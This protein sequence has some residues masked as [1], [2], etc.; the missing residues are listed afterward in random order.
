MSAFQSAFNST[1]QFGAQQRALRTQIHGEQENVWNNKKEYFLNSF[2]D[3]ET[4][5]FLS[6]QQITESPELSARAAEFMNDPHV[7]RVFFNGRKFLGMVPT[8]RGTYTMAVMGDD[9]KP[10]PVTATGATA[11]ENPND[12]VLEGTP[13][14]LEQLWGRMLD[15]TF[16]RVNSMDRLLTG[17]EN[18]KQQALGGIGD[19]EFQANRAEMAQIMAGPGATAH[20]AGDFTPQVTPLG[21]TSSQVQQPQR[22]VVDTV[23]DRL[24]DHEGAEGDTTGAAETGKIGVTAAARKAVGGKDKTDEQVARE[25]LEQLKQKMPESLK[26]APESVQRAILDSAYNLGESIFRYPKL[27]AAAEKGDWQGVAQELLDTASIAGKSSRGLASRR[28]QAYNEIALENGF[29]QIKKVDQSED[30]KIKYLDETGSVLFEYKAKN[31]RH[32]TSG[33]GQLVIPGVEQNRR[34]DLRNPPTAQ[35]IYG[36]AP[37]LLPNRGTGEGSGWTEEQLANAPDGWLSKLGDSIRERSKQIGEVRSNRSGQ[38]EEAKPA[39]TDAEVAE[40]VSITTDRPQT[41]VVEKINKPVPETDPEVMQ[42]TLQAETARF[43]S[44]TT[45]PTERQLD[46]SIRAI[47]KQP[48]SKNFIRTLSIATAQGLLTPAQSIE[49]LNVGRDYASKVVTAEANYN[50]LRAQEEAALA[51][52]RKRVNDD[53]RAQVEFSNKQSD[54]LRDRMLE[55]RKLGIEIE[56]R[57]REVTKTAFEEAIPQALVGAGV[58]ARPNDKGTGLQQQIFAGM[59]PKG[60]TDA[61]F[62]TMNQNESLMMSDYGLDLRVVRQRGY[63]TPDERQRLDFY[64]RTA[65]SSWSATRGDKTRSSNV[66]TFPSP[67]S[68]VYQVGREK[69]TLHEAR[70]MLS[71]ELGRPVTLPEVDA[72]LRQNGAHPVDLN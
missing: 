18:E 20:P 65:T 51:L 41:E 6:A 32:S 52:S 19:P 69:R 68:T 13:E 5:K 47:Y 55:D 49:M 34:H 1:L 36:N 14:Q 42:D 63:L 71:D 64:V 39:T 24:I 4:G 38:V 72:W 57:F 22:T 45:P 15:K 35:H 62:N 33:I 12:P 21:E 43:Q 31:G 2:T 10:A 7:N 53:H 61:L 40:Q 3:P 17:V 67:D 44:A 26:N 58:E 60:L 46:A 50:K 48:T 66:S 25:Y 56:D 54:R 16:S 27:M 30:G 59:T 70:A 8:D 29:P 37:R 23:F 11:A 28:A 9:G